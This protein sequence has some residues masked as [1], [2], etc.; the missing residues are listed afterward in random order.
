[1]DKLAISNSHVE[2]KKQKASH[3]NSSNFNKI[4]TAIKVIIRIANWARFENVSASLVFNV[5][6]IHVQTKK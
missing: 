4:W 2:F 1:M 3:D 5:R 6:V